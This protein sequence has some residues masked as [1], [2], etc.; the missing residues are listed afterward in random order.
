MKD[1]IKDWILNRL[2]L[3]IDLDPPIFPVNVRDG[4]IIAELLYSYNVINASQLE[5]V[6]T[7]RNSALIK[8][9]TKRLQNW[10]KTF[11]GV[12]IHNEFFYFGESGSY[13][14]K[15]LDQLYSKLTNNKQFFSTNENRA[16]EEK[17]TSTSRLKVNY[18]NDK[19]N[20]KQVS[21]SD[22][23]LWNYKVK[24]GEVVGWQ[25][26]K[27]QTLLEDVQFNREKKFNDFIYEGVGVREVE[28]SPAI[29][30]SRSLYIKV[31]NEIDPNKKYTVED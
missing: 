13:T 6:K 26:D 29:K 18:N 20:R 16:N 31:L 4:R 30:A 15:F 3:K 12:K 27:F 21:F 8:E 1:L 14:L 7:T 11:L 19:Y 5:L 25:K 9:N 10:L 17:L 22:E 28:P 2:G 24:D 23:P